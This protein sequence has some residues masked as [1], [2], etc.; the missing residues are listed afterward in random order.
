MFARRE[1][2]V[3][4]HRCERL[5]TIPAVGPITAL[6]WALE[7]GDVQRFSS[8]KKAV[9]Y[10]GL[11]GAENSQWKRGRKMGHDNGSIRLAESNQINQL[12]TGRVTGHMV[13]R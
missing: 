7:V 12:P 10:C 5:M 3:A 13:L 11:C 2:Q 8:I 1:P 6:T 4:R 9:S